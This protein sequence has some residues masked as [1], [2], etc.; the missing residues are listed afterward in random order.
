MC[1]LNPRK[2]PADSQA[3]GEHTLNTNV[4]DYGD[5]ACLPLLCL[6]PVLNM[7]N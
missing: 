3:Y 5:I 6:F 1:F 2:S 7:K 4:I